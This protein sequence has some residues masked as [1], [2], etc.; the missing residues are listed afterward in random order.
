MTAQPIHHAT[1]P[2][3]PKTV[4]GVRS[5]LPVHLRAKFETELG[6]AV[7]TGDMAVVNLVKDKWWGQ[8]MWAND[9]EADEV[10]AALT[11]GEAELVESPF[12]R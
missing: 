12:A 7:D 11:R 5:Y 1:P 10:L 6:E 2:R 4:A 3:I 8:A 9:P